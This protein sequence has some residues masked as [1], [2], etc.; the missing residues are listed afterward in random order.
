MVNRLRGDPQFFADGQ[1]DLAQR[2]NK[3]VYVIP[4]P[5]QH[6]LPDED[7]FSVSQQQRRGSG[8]RVVCVVSLPHM[9][10]SDD[11][12][13]VAND[14]LWQVQ[15]CQQPPAEQ[16]DAIICRVV[17]IVSPTR[18]LLHRPWAES[19]LRNGRRRCPNRWRLRRLSSPWNNPLMTHM[20]PMAQGGNCSGLGLLPVTTRM[21]A[22]KL[23]RP[24]TPACQASP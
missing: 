21:D 24:L 12:E 10:M 18:I 9:A 1:Q 17:P 20:P 2:I 5:G 11:L 13:P 4:A 22:K 8:D 14:P 6:G 3:P 23:V 15:W 7:G 19:L 16:P